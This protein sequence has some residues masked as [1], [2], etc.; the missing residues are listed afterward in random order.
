MRRMTSK[1]SER[2]VVAPMTALLMV[3]L[4]GMAAFAVDVATMYSEHAQL[5][6]GADASALAIANQCSKAATPCAA[7]QA[8]AASGYANGNALDAHS[9]VV[10]AIAD[11]GAGTVDVTIQSQTADGSSNHFSLQ[12]AKVIGI[13][14][15]D[16]SAS[17]R[18]KWGYPSSGSG[19][20]LAFSQSCW[21]LGPATPT[22]GDVQKITWKPGTPSCTNAS[23]LTIPG[24]WGW[25]DDASTDPCTAVTSVG[26]FTTS[27]PGNNPPTTCQTILQSWKNTLT[28]GGVVKVTFPIFD[29]ASG[30][31]NTGVFHIVGY[32]TFSIMG[33]HFGNASGPYEFRDTSTDPGMNANLACSSGND[34]CII[35]QFV[36]YSTSIGGSGGSDFG[37]SSVSLTK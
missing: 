13:P 33:W 36:E 28:A 35:G 20:P 15:A 12:F 11:A 19:F 3:F 37:T 4:L 25:L 2:G 16:I 17:A 8:A 22:G 34:R 10:S 32:A 5:Q 9:N 18:A 6:N 7:D 23:G 31:G 1:G 24:G 26:S 14:T 29:T 27:N 30:S 21:N